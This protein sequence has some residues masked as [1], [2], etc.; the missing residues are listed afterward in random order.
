M[1]TKAASD[2][3]SIKGPTNDVTKIKL[4]RVEP[5]TNRPE[6]IIRTSEAAATITG[7]FMGLIDK[8]NTHASH[9]QTMRRMRHDTGCFGM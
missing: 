8:T 2:S 1:T 9:I 3:M 6:Q 7:S 5:K 4:G